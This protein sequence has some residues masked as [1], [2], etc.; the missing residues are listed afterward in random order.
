MS[1]ILKEGKGRVTVNGVTVGEFSTCEIDT[2]F[3][4]KDIFIID[5]YNWMI[6]H[7]HCNQC[8]EEWTLSTND[9]KCIIC[10][11]ED[12]RHGS[13]DCSGGYGEGEL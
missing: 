2:N 11:S 10:E 6:P 8:G 5:H 13:E 4:S 12:I 9:Y 7:H 3:N 1:S